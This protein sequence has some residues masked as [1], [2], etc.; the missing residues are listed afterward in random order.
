MTVAPLIMPGQ[1]ATGATAPSSG[2]GLDVDTATDIPFLIKAD[3]TK[4][5]FGG[6]GY[7]K[8]NIL[9]YG[10]D[11]TGVANNDTALTN[12]IAALG[13]NGGIIEIPSG[14]YLFA[15]AFN[16]SANNIWIRCGG[17]NATVLKCNATTG[18]FLTFSGYG[19]GISDGSVQGPGSG[20][21]SSKASGYT[22]NLTGTEAFCVAVDFAYSYDTLGLNGPL[23]DADDLICRYFAHSGIVV[24]QNSD[25]R[26]M[27][28][29]MDNNAATLPTGS[30]IDV[31]LTASLV[32]AQLNVIHSNF[33]LNLS[34]AVSTTV[35]SIKAT[36][37]FFDTSAIGI[38]F[39]GAGS[40]FRS[41]FTN[42]WCGSMS[43]AGI[44][45][46]PTTAGNMVDGIT[47]VNC[48]IYNNVAGTTN[49]IHFA[50]AN[51][52][53]VDFQNCRVAG[54]TNGVN[55]A[56]GT[57]G[58]SFPR[59]L[60]CAIGAQS[61]FGVNTVGILVAAISVYGLA[62][63]TCDVAA[64]GNTTVLTLGAVT[65]SVPAAFRITDNAGI[66]PRGAVT[67]PGIPASTVNATNTT[68]FKVLVLIKC[69][70]TAPTAIGVNGV[71]FAQA[72]LASQM[73]SVPLEPGGTINMTYTVA[74]TAWTWIGQ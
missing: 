65:A 72:L 71:A 57:S 14:A 36:N 54:W 50:T 13:A 59:I 63:D 6:P 21:T 1:A 33:A 51:Y 68:G 23:A 60:S 43:T 64:A 66:N 27:R 22:V 20:T 3:G 30:G 24:N 45:I 5:F 11:R 74:P 46:G 41:E 26:I 19:S 39:A 34:P 42:V 70:A 25:H 10:G 31:Q 16:V 40:V 73:F 52:G 56:A 18:D 44:Y 62:I 15:A 7:G 61:A 67:T 47:F 12:A 2:Y 29:T 17:T 38:R 28:V 49:G 58:Q 4:K 32:M 35:P 9:D 53:R 48:S 69:A 55:I 37:C 8:V